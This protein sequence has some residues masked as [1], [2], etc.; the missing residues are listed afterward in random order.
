MERRL[1]ELCM[2][3]NKPNQHNKDKEHRDRQDQ[4]TKSSLTT[5]YFLNKFRPLW[6][7]PSVV[8][9][10]QYNL[11]ILCVKLREAKGNWTVTLRP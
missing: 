6:Q 10:K 2:W 7:I 9:Q 11:G 3:R 8:T 4:I 5:N 1:S